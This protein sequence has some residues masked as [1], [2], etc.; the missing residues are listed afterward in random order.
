[1]VYFISNL[2]DLHKIWNLNFEFKK[3]QIRKLIDFVNRNK[4][5]IIHL[6]IMVKTINMAIV[7]L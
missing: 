6:I 4:G 5:I 1:V 7:A 3:S 2:Q